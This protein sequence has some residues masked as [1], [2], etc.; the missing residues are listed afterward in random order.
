LQEGWVLSVD[1]YT[2][3]LREK[4]K[5]KGM[6]LHRLNKHT[7]ASSEGKCYIGKDSYRPTP[8]GILELEGAPRRREEKQVYLSGQ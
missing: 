5:E 7:Y 4:G 1:F 6:H 3:L 2:C 8:E